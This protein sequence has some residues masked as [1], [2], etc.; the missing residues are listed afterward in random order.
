MKGDRLQRVRSVRE[1]QERV[2]RVEWAAAQKAAAAAADTVGDLVAAEAEARAALAQNLARGPLDTRQVLLDQDAVD[3]IGAALARARAYARDAQRIADQKR[4]PWAARRA[5]AEALRR[6]EERHL[7]L[8]RMDANK[9]QQALQDE[10]AG[11]RHQRRD[12]AELGADVTTTTDCALRGAPA[13]ESN[14]ITTEDPQ[15]NIRS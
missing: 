5:E 7:T 12:R 14:P 9:R 10:G 4:E 13:A 8:A 15:E 11:V 6:L 1:L 2:L 3:G